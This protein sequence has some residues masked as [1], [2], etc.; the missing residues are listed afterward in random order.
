MKLLKF[1]VETHQTNQELI[2]A[3][4]IFCGISVKNWKGNEINKSV[5]FKYDELIIKEFV[6]LYHKC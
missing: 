4:N 6:S 1:R 5:D 2:C 3:R